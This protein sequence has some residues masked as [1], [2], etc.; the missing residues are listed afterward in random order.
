MSLKFW[1]L[2]MKITDTGS[3]KLLTFNEGKPELKEH[4]IGAPI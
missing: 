2:M 3:L 4:Y 1:E